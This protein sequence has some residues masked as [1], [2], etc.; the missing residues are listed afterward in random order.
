MARGPIPDFPRERPTVPE[1]APLVDYYLGLYPAGG[2]LHIVL[3]DGNLAED[4]IRWCYQVA[5][6]D[7]WMAV[8]NYPNGGWDTGPVDHLG[9]ALALLILTMT[10]TQRR[11][12]Y[13]GGW[14]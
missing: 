12:I 2:S 14:R 3:E 1:V 10:P 6:T 5:I 8:E 9:A 7:G 4:H 13:R 11:K